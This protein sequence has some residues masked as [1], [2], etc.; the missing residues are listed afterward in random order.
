MFA[1][2]RLWGAP[3]RALAI[4]LA[5][6]ACVGA[7]GDGGDTGQPG[8]VAPVSQ[9]QS[10]CLNI[11]PGVAPLRRLLESEYNNTVRDLLG[12]TSN[13][14]NAFPPDQKVGDFSNTATALTVSPLLAQSYEAAAEQIATNAVA[15]LSALSS[16]DTTTTGEDAC[17]T[18]FIQTF[19]KRAFRRPL[20][21][22]EQTALTTLYQSNKSAAD[23]NNGIQSVIEAILQSAAFLYRPEFGLASAVQGGVVPLTSYEMASRLSYFLWSSMPDDALFAAADADVLRSPAQI[24]GQANRLLAD[25]KAQPAVSQFFSEWLGVDD[26]DSAPKDPATYPPYTPDVQSAMQQETLAFTDWVMWQSDARLATLLTAPVSFMNQSLAQFYGITG[27][28]G[29]AFQQVQLDPTERAGILTQGA[30]MSV[31]GKADREALRCS[32]GSSSARSCSARTS[33]R[34][35]RTSSSRHRP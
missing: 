12:D 10:A 23:Y 33:R 18:Q 30:V 29:T 8:S 20:T 17:A 1:A 19:G 3:V 25:P 21:Q 9:T 22:D 2:R 6:A 24:A 35:R 16:C 26:I 28:T 7:V 11:S 32:A 27:V 4:S 15:N 14:A 13:P 5:L 34:R 31:T